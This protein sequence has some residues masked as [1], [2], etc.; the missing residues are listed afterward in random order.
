[1]SGVILTVNRNRRN[2]ELLS[3]LLD[4]QGYESLCATTLEEFDRA[5]ERAAH[6]DLALVDVAGFDQE[7]W[8]RCDRL[9]DGAIPFLVISAHGLAGVGAAGVRH[10][11]SGML[12]KPLI[13]QELL[14][15]IQ[16]L[17]KK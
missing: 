7:V 12:V 3:R 8:S 10:G 11:A 9:R 13:G 16:G 15:L 2:A 14:A 4:Q 17:L 5:L 6:I 1:M